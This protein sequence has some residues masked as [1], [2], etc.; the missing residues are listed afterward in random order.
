MAGVRSQ[1]PILT[2]R[3]RTHAGFNLQS[4]VV[5][6]ID[7]SSHRLVGIGHSI[8]SISLVLS[9]DYFPSIEG[10]FSSGILVEPMMMNEKAAAVLTVDSRGQFRSVATYFK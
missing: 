10:L 5:P 7:F 9:L 2:G 8:G 1:N 4:P 3:G 6:N